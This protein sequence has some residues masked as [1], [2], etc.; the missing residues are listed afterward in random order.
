MKALNEDFN[1]E[2]FKL[3]SQVSLTTSFYDSITLAGRIGMFSRAT[4]NSNISFC[5]AKTDELGQA[6]TGVEYLYVP[7]KSWTWDD[8]MKKS[9]S[10]G[11]T[12]WDAQKYLNIWVCHLADSVSCY[13]QMPGGPW[14]TD[15]IVVD[16]RFFG[17]DS[18]DASVKKPYDKG[19][20]LTHLIGNYLNL[21]DLWNYY[22]RCQDD[23]VSDTPVHN[24]PTSG[25]DHYRHISTCDGQ[26][27]AMTMNF[28]DNTDDACMYMFTNGQVTRMQAVLAENGWR[29]GLSK[30][31]ETG[32]YCTQTPLTDDMLPDKFWQKEPEERSKKGVIALHVAPNP[33]REKIII[34]MVATDDTN[35]L[36]RLTNVTGKEVYRQKQ[37]LIKGLSTVEINSAAWPSGIYFVVLNADGKPYSCMVVV[38]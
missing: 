14:E 9:E 32:M 26:P 21:Y 10:S 24:A 4:Q 31:G 28:M 5:L 34:S 2:T 11:L 23:N 7:S 37:G 27:D 16:H 20:T 12:G 29:S 8:A 18:E 30:W 13:A 36:L 17:C 19:K 25:C 6:T 1:G 35:G 22:S 33:A 38:E 15:G 3:E